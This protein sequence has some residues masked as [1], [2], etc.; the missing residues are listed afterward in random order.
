M[1]TVLEDLKRDYHSVYC[2]RLD[3]G[4]TIELLRLSGLFDRERLA[5]MEY[6]GCAEVSEMEA[7][8]V[9]RFME[10][11]V[12]PSLRPRN[13]MMRDASLPEVPHNG[14]GYRE[15]SEQLKNSCASEEWLRRF[16][17]FCK[18]CEGFRVW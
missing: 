3:W 6:N 14:T 7:R 4:C 13:R 10:I 12:L 18:T 8:A 15:P 5:V 2:N 11:N 9:A 1:S 16:I 17:E